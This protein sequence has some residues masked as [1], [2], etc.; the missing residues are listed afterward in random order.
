MTQFSSP[1]ESWQLRQASTQAAAEEEPAAD[2]D[3]FGKK[4]RYPQPQRPPADPWTPTQQLRKRKTLP[5]RMGFLMKVHPLLCLE[6]TF[7][8]SS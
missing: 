3:P 1:W 8:R 6:N 5:K 7:T 2:F 4:Q